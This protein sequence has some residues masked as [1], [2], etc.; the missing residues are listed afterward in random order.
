MDDGSW[1]V[2]DYKSEASADYASVVKEYEVSMRVYVEASRQIVK[3]AE[4]SG[5]LHFTETGEFYRPN[6]S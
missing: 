6:F 3:S 2:I 5:Y 4:I 1:V